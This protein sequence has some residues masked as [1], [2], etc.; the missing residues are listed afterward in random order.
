MAYVGWR[1][2]EKELTCFVI[3]HFQRLIVIK[4]KEVVE[5][6]TVIKPPKKQ[7]IDIK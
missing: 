1:A 7:L 5:K 2:G 4:L 6:L 3:L